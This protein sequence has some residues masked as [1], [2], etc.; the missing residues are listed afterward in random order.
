MREMTAGELD[1]WYRS[2][3]WPC[4]N[5]PAKLYS[6]PGPQVNGMRV[7]KCVRC[8]T[9]INVIDPE[10]GR[11]GEDTAIGQVLAVPPGYEPPKVTLWRR[12]AGFLQRRQP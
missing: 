1:R 7:L 11:G 3:R 4:C 2:H 10:A 9:T 6:S 8:G 12:M 5:N